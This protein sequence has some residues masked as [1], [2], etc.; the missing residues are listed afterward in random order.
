[1]TETQPPYHSGP[2]VLVGASVRAAAQSARRGGFQVI[3]IDIFGDTDTRDAC[4]HY[5]QIP[6]NFRSAGPAIQEILNACAGLPILTVGGL[7]GA[8]LLVNSLVSAGQHMG[9][10]QHV[11]D[12]LDQ[13]NV[14]RELA[15]AAG[16]R[17][18]P[19]VDSAESVSRLGSTRWLSKRIGS[20]GGL[21]VRW[22][23]A[24][25]P[26]DSSEIRQQWIPGRA[27]G[28][29]YLSDGCDVQLIGV[30]RSQFTRIGDLPFVYAGSCGPIKLDP[31]LISK[32]EKLGTL[33]VESLGLSGLFN[34]DLVIDSNDQIWLLEINP[35]WSGSTE[36][37]ESSIVASGM[38][39]AP[40][41]LLSLA[42]KRQLLDSAL[43]ASCASGSS[44]R[45][46]LK[47]IVYAR[48]DHRFSLHRCT[49]SLST[50]QSLHD[51]PC[52]GTLIRRGEPVATL[53][54]CY[55]SR[56]SAYE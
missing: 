32:L 40:S 31:I 12:T 21:G 47:R 18:P 42:L 17:V 25:D 4:D 6:S 36:I 33:S 55:F 9:T 3:G 22:W 56:S 24:G 46:W 54:G 34:I 11:C 5:F 43:A 29:T 35:R 49:Q 45:V 7:N 53:V 8:D 30:C 26:I 51:V 48:N 2:I 15:T 37:I 52:E 28:V 10:P 27:Y 16:I 41:S 19:T 38:T 44:H 13:P 1:M 14:L 20:S 39:G 50:N 23:H